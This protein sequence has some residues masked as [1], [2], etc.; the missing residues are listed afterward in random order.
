[1]FENRLAPRVSKLEDRFTAIDGRLDSVET[2]V[3]GLGGKIDKLVGEL[4]NTDGRAAQR[5]QAAKTEM[6]EET[7]RKAKERSSMMRDGLAL[8]GGV[9]LIVTALVGPYRERLSSTAQGQQA[10]T[11]AISAVREVL[12]Q[13]GAAIGH[14]DAELDAQRDTD[15]RH[16]AEL[17]EHDRDLAYERGF[18]DARAGARR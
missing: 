17:R 13:Q 15:K 11:V 14:N 8:L 18:R 1:M 6:R 10:D 7:D 16:E 2:A 3:G 5:A 9:G 12:A 4:T